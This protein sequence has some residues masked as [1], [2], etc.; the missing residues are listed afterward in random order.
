MNET[1]KIKA[2]KIIAWIAI[3]SST[4]TS[5]MIVTFNIF[6]FDILTDIGKIFLFTSYSMMISYFLLLYSIVY[7]SEMNKNW[8]KELNE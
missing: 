5:L 4:F 1:T 3:I 2:L 6:Y 8:V 7:L